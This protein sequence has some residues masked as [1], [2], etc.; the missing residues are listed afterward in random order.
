MSLSESQDPEISAMSAI[1]NALDHL[2]EDARARVLAWA[3]SRYMPRISQ[4]GDS[5]A[6]A[7]PTS[8]PPSP[9]TSGSGETLAEFFADCSPQDDA[10]RVLVAATFLRR[11]GGTEVFTAAQAHADLI[12]LGYR[13]VNITRVLEGLEAQRPA[14]VVMVRK[15]GKTKQARKLY[16]VTEAGLRNVGEMRI[17]LGD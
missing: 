15:E 12:Q 17:G 14:L 2:P 7:P 6:F 1:A 10:Q 3:R 13:I 8:P 11:R 9:S 5:T 4:L 16:K